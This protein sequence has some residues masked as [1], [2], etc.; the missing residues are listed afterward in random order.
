V[1]V[2]VYIRDPEPALRDAVLA[3][4][5]RQSPPLAVSER[6]V[7]AAVPLREPDDGCADIVEHI[8]PSAAVPRPAETVVTCAVPLDQAVGILPALFTA[9]D[10][11]DDAWCIGEPLA[12]MY[13]DRLAALRAALP[14][15]E[16]LGREFGYD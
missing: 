12:L 15:V 2:V 14:D 4:A 13:P 8:D 16:I 5:A 1:L 6:T 9:V 11:P 3:F 7:S 10:M